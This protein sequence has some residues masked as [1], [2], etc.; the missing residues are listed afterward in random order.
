MKRTF[1]VLVAVGL[2]ALLTDACSG[3]SEPSD[4]PPRR[5]A[6]DEAETT[7]PEGVAER[8][9]EA[10]RRL[11]PG[12]SVEVRDA[13]RVIIDGEEA[14]LANLAP[15]CRG[16]SDDCSAAIA[17]WARAAVTPI[18]TAT[19]ERVRAVLLPLEEVE[20]ARDQ[21]R[22][23]G[24]PLPLA[25]RPFVGAL[26]ES[27][28]I[29]EPDRIV[30]IGEASL[31]ELGDPTL[32][33]L[34]ELALEN[35]RE[36][37]AEEM[38][39]TPFDPVAAPSVRVVTIGDSYENARVLLHERWARVAAAV[40]GD[41]IVAAPARDRVIYTGAASER[42]VASLRW[43]AQQMVQHEPHPIAPTVLR[44]TEAGW[45]LFHAND[46][47]DPAIDAILRQPPAP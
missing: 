25:G 33:E 47:P 41:L 5:R 2:A 44:W 3:G 8:F 42:D 27:F 22:E 24:L 32:D 35:M 12:A 14:D 29:D 4:R 38:P 31:D 18:G 15:E 37:F 21:A 17:R 16:A 6:T 23:Q 9:A 40:S 39:T 28:V 26:Y 45:V 34:H 20:R 10:V 19:R 46:R 11:R 36:A 30:H 13:R 1:I 43:L 7:P